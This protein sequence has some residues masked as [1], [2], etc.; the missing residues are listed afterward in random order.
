MKAAWS[1]W[2]TLTGNDLLAEAAG[3][4]L[5]SPSH[6]PAQHVLFSTAECQAEPFANSA[7]N[8]CIPTS[9]G[10]ND[11][12][13]STHTSDGLLGEWLGELHGLNFPQ[14]MHTQHQAEMV[15]QRHGQS[16]GEQG[17]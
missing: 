5:R 17:G 3:F 16:G 14:L 2:C 13:S 10:G 4:I 9:Q 15:L 7:P 6:P 11:L 8:Y 12:D 1:L